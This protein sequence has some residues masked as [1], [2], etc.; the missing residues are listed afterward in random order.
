MIISRTPFRISFFGGGTDYPAW[1]RKEFGAVL[2]TTIDKYCYLTCRCLPLFFDYTIRIVY[3]HIEMGKDVDKIKHPAVRET[4]RFMKISGGLEI[5]HASDLPARGGLG[6]SSSFIV[7]LL[8]TLSVLQGKTPDR[9]EMARAAIHIERDLIGEAVGSQDQT[10]ASFGGL[11][12]IR[13][14]GEDQIRVKPISLDPERVAALESHLM[15]YFT[16]ILRHAPEFAA[17]QIEEI[18][19]HHSDLIT[20]RQMVDEGIQMLQEGKHLDNFGRLLHESWQIKRGLA[21]GITNPTI[22]E[23][24]SSAC[25]AGAL[26]GKLLGAGGGG[27]ILFFVRPQD[28]ARVRERLSKL[29]KI[30]FRFEKSGTQI[31]LRDNLQTLTSL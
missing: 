23:I 14:S 20:M 4:F 6:A 16:G 2:S 26:G 15:L 11:N 19:K 31:I 13:F 10:A 8:H 24:Y 25:E 21:D 1:Y 28:Q 3:S 18:G 22:E 17:R 29:V 9:L 5:N 7:G 30:P 27:F 12:H